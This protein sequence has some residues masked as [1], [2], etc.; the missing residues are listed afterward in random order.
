[1]DATANLLV[2]MLFLSGFYTLLSMLTTMT[3]RLIGLHV[4]ARRRARTRMAVPNDRHQGRR[5][6]S[7]PPRRP[8][9]QLRA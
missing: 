5:R 4:P 8:R 7:L 9:Q 3:G 2:L 6:R 1:M